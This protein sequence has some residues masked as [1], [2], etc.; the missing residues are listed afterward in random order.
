V[1]SNERLQEAL[2]QAG[3]WMQRAQESFVAEK[4]KQAD[5]EIEQVG[6]Q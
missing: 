3:T 6:I 1:K 2:R 4:W 5:K